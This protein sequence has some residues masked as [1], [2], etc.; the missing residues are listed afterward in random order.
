MSNS[1]NLKSWREESM[2]PAPSRC[3]GWQNPVDF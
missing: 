1:Y 2:D 3:D